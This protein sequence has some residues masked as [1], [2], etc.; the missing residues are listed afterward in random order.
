MVRAAFGGD[1]ISL[2]LL[3]LASVENMGTRKQG[4]NS[5]RSAEEAALSARLDRLGERLDRKTASR[6]S[7]AT[8]AARTDT[9]AMAR[10][11]RLS[12]ELVAGVVVGAGV[13]WLL[14]RWLGISPWGFIV[15]LLLGFAAGM[16]NV[17]RS[18]RMAAERDQPKR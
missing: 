5:D 17:M 16:L 8:P 3:D 15:F 10:G 13:G 9:S 14:D 1:R 18:A 12:T 11:M 6:S 2:Q 7:E 4:D